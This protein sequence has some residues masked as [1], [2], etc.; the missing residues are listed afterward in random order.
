MGTSALGIGAAAG[1]FVEKTSADANYRFKDG[2]K[3]QIIDVSTGQFREIWI[4]DGQIKFGPK[5]S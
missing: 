2:E 3:I 4:E 5:E 1:D